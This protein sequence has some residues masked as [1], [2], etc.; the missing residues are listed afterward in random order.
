MAITRT[1]QGNLVET[2][3]DS[4]SGNDDQLNTNV[5]YAKEKTENTDKKPGFLRSTIIELK[6]VTWPT[7]EY[8]IRWSLIII[9]FT[10]FFSIILGFVD[11]IFESSVK[12]VDCTSP[13][14]RNQPVSTCNN[15]FL[16]DITLQS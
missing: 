8:V 15:E 14:G 13:Q 16:A 7:I 4:N 12:Y 1:K 10:A 3:V 2:K 5:Q 6:K 9:A 11:M